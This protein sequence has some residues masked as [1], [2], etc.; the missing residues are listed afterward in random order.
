M[1]QSKFLETVIWDDK[2]KKWKTNIIEVQEYHGNIECKN[3]NKP[4]SYNVKTNNEFKVVYVR[5]G[6]NT[7]NSSDI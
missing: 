2:N 7:Q 6:C 1:E 4:L 5:C 3:C